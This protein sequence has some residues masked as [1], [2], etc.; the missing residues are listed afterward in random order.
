MNSQCKCDLAAHN[1]KTL[2]CFTEDSPFETKHLFT[3]ATLF[4]A[5]KVKTE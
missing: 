1:H 3:A 2:D 5:E 4:N